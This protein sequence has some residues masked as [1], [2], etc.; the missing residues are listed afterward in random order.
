[1]RAGLAAAGVTV[2]G[3]RAGIGV[4]VALVPLRAVFAIFFS[5]IAA[6]DVGDVL[7]GGVGDA[8]STVVHGF[9]AKLGHVER[10]GIKFRFSWLWSFRDRFVSIRSVVEGWKRWSARLGT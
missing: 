6:A 4:V 7:E 2:A 3:C 10:R 8:F 5:E 9:Q 1:M